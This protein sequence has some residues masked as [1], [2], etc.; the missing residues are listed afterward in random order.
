MTGGRQAS[1]LNG[2]RFGQTEP[3][4]NQNWL[5]LDG[6]GIYVPFGSQRLD[7]LVDFPTPGTPRIPQIGTDGNLSFIDP[8]TSYQPLD[9]DLTAIASLATTTYGRSKLTLVDTAA[10]RLAIN[11]GRDI[12]YGAT[13]PTVR[14][15]GT[16]LAIGDQWYDTA[17]QW[18]NYWDGTRWL[19]QQVFIANC[20]H[21]AGAVAAN[22]GIPIDIPSATFSVFLL[23]FATAMARVGPQDATSHY[24]ASFMRVSPTAVNTP[25]ATLT[26]NEA[27]ASGAND[28]ITK[29]A[30]LNLLLDTTT[31]TRAYRVTGTRVGTTNGGLSS[32][33]CRVKY[34]LAYV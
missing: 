28:A 27:L 30:A 16:T 14:S 29:E 9:S 1:K 5:R 23:N 11:N 32:F 22:I 4:V 17:N 3:T 2:L 15:T 25:L 18:W 7:S 34:R 19:T 21:T 20:H 33:Q 31:N 24:T 6:S 12:Q 26:F 13:K 10:E 8:A